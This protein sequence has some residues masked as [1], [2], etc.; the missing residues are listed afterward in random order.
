[1]SSKSLVFTCFFISKKIVLTAAIRSADDESSWPNMMAIVLIIREG[2][3]NAL[4]PMAAGEVKTKPT[5][6][7][8]VHRRPNN[9]C[10]AA[11]KKVVKYEVSTTVGGRHNPV[12]LHQSQRSLHLIIQFRARIISRHT[13]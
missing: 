4:L 7:S 6:C 9:Q 8:R 12:N 13:H 3:K 2:H 1:M 5:S 10:S 11:P